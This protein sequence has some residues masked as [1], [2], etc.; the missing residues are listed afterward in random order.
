MRQTNIPLSCLPRLPLPWRRSNRR[1]A[2]LQSKLLII[3]VRKLSLK[4]PGQRQRLKLRLRW[5]I[6]SGTVWFYFQFGS[7]K[8]VT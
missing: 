7:M 3:S 4:P 1:S 5:T 6:A 2:S 8:Q